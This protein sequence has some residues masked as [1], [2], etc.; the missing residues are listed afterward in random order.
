M[1]LSHIQSRMAE[2]CPSA[3]VFGMA[4]YSGWNNRALEDRLLDLSNEA[5]AIRATA[6]RQN[7]DLTE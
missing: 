2:I 3:G 6:E 7:R 5:S 4:D 1:N